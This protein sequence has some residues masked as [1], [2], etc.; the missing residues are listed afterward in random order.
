MSERA[1]VDLSEKSPGVLY[2]VATPIGNLEDITLRALRILKEA[3]LIAAEDTR[4]T[5][6]LLTHY[7]I[8]KPLISYHEHN[9]R[10]REQSLLAELQEGKKVALV[11]DAGTPGISDP[12]EDLVRAA[13][14][15]SISLIPVPGPSALISALSVSGLPTES[16][17]FHGFPPSKASARRIFLSSLKERSETL[18]F[19]ES[20]RRLQK[21]L[22]DARDILGDRR[23]VVAREITKVFEEVRRGTLS[24]ILDRFGKEEVRGEITIVMEGRPAPAEKES[25]SVG[26]ALAHHRQDGLSWK[27]SIAQVSAE[28]G[29]PRREV[30]QE[31]LR[32]RDRMNRT[33]GNG[34][35]PG[36]NR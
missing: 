17:L 9:R 30:Y 23:C 3:D 24:E 27:E 2:I 26:D 25:I 1:S 19:Y 18:I 16:F 33:E 13:I 14:Q 6:Q 20:P 5:R 31:S 22:E 12:G 11:T 8:H 4:R 7:G 29:I 36:K 32:I 10:L 35:F 28:L 21:F 15:E 34:G